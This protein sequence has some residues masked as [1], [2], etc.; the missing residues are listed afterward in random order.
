MMKEN[1][2]SPPKP[3]CFF[4]FTP[5]GNKSIRRKNITFLSSIHYRQSGKFQSGGHTLISTPDKVA[6]L[7]FLFSLVQSI[8]YIS[9]NV[10]SSF[11][12]SHLLR[13]KRSPFRD[14]L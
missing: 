10:C 6:F 3:L 13:E 11:S 9:S 2:Q 8:S 12:L 5:A 1:I 14:S 7:F 4:S